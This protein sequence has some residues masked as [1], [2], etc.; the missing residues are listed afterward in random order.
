MDLLL[1]AREPE[2]VAKTYAIHA[3]IDTKTMARRSFSEAVAAGL[4]DPLTG[5]YC[6]KSTGEHVYVGDAIKKGLIK[7]TVVIDSNTL[8]IEPSNRLTLPDANINGF[9]KQQNPAAA[10]GTPVSNDVRSNANGVTNGA[11]N[12]MTNGSRY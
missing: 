1:F 5:A 11:V 10:S 12:R 7:A 3:V 9:R 2:Y 6:N 8:D 4:I